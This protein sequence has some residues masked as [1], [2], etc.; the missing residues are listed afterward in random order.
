MRR[1]ASHRNSTGLHVGSG[2]LGMSQAA[3]SGD[4]LFAS[5]CLARGMRVDIY[6]PQREPEFLASSVSFADPH[7]Q[8][9][10]HSLKDLPELLFRIMPDEL[11]PCPKKQMFTTG[12]TA[13]CCTQHC[14]V[15]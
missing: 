14:L 13:G 10:H 2:D 9:D 15:D 8:R 1:R 6:L 7:W 11:G 4:L 5:A 12:V 3:A